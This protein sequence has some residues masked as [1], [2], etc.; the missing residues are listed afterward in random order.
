[1]RI[2][3]IHGILDENELALSTSSHGRTIEFLFWIN[4]KAPSSTDKFEILSPMTQ[5]AYGMRIYFGLYVV[6]VRSRYKSAKDA[7]GSLTE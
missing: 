3:V 2:G 4:L 1:M 6:V 5:F 7:S